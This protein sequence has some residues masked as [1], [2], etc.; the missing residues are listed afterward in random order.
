MTRRAASVTPPLKLWFCTD[1]AAHYVG[2][3]SIVVAETERQ[4]RAL[5][6]EELRAHG[7]RQP[8]GD[9]TLV[10]VDLTQQAAI[11]LANGDY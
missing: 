11:V 7:L 1:H 8:E 10:L 4:A 9:F 3:A 5:L 6:I 2:G